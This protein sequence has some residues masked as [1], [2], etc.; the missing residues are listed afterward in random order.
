MPADG[1]PGWV[2]S[3]RSAPKHF[4]S[5]GVYE[6]DRRMVAHGRSPGPNSRPFN[7]PFLA[8]PLGRNCMRLQRIRASRGCVPGTS[9]RR[10]RGIHP[11]LVPSRACRPIESPNRSLSHSPG[12]TKPIAQSNCCSWVITQH[13]GVATQRRQPF[14]LAPKPEFNA[15]GTELANAPSTFMLRLFGYV[16]AAALAAHTE[17]E[18]RPIAAFFSSCHPVRLSAPL[19]QG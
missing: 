14:H 2:I 11:I 19:S 1:V 13:N 17:V 9:Q 5:H 6:G 15:H 10:G 16:F 3:T 8:V 12:G 18:S 7:P 4:C